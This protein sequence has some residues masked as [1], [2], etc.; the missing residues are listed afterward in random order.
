M[1][2]TLHVVQQAKVVL[3]ADDGE[4]PHSTAPRE[5]QALTQRLQ[6]LLSPLAVNVV[7]NDI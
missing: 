5:L 1:C 2:T 4:S 3:E 7:K 6:K